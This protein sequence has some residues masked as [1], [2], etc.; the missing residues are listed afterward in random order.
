MAVIRSAAATVLTTIA[1]TVATAVAQ[2][3][4]PGDCDSDGLVSIDELV[5]GVA[6]TLAPGSRSCAAMDGD[7]NGTVT[8]AELVAA[9]GAA[10]EGCGPSPTATPIPD[11]PTPSPTEAC[12]DQETIGR[13][14][15][16]IAARTEP[17]CVDAG[18]RWGPYPYS[19][20][21]GCFCETGQGG[22]PCSASGDCLGL[23]YADRQ[24]SCDD[25]ERGRCTDEVPKAG[26]FCLYQSNG[27]LS[28]LCIDP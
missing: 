28:V 10:L 14:A 21:P 11:P 22:C 18:G 19:R 17:D 25:A 8:I 7:H 15:A 2:P 5:T 1:V 26:C 13:F 12:G 20:R 23:C 27:Q 24:N 9:V 3:P 16:C 4:C 6:L